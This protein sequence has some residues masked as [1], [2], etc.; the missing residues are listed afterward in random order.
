[1]IYYSLP[2]LK[3]YWEEVYSCV[4]TEWNGVVTGE[5]FKQGLFKALELAQAKKARYWVSDLRN[6]QPQSH[7]E[8]HEY[9]QWVIEEWL[10]I[11]IKTGIIK[12]AVISVSETIITRSL[13]KAVQAFNMFRIAI[14]YFDDV[15]SAFKW[16]HESNNGENGLTKR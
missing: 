3:V 5:Q 9:K 12:I 8:M 13:M 15:E 11:L 6:L 10:P 7:Q 1:M 14:E 16:I 2:Y 4:H